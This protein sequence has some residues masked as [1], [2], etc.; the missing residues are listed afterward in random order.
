MCRSKT[1]RCRC[2]SESPPTRRLC[3]QRP[4]RGTCGRSGASGNR[5]RPCFAADSLPP[6]WRQG[7]SRGEHAVRRAI[8]KVTAVSNATGVGSLSAT[9]ECQGEEEEGQGWRYRVKGG[10]LA[11]E[12]DRCA[13]CGQK[14]SATYM[15]RGV[16]RC[17]VCIRR[18][19][20]CPDC[21]GLRAGAAPWI[22]MPAVYCS[23]PFEAVPEQP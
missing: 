10:S 17:A 18:R 3:C 8:G 21:G 16:R 15:G 20:R 4:R 19:Y 5:A 9:A 13:E 12:Q 23:C 6:L 7:A 14:R 1:R 11:P 22:E 2:V